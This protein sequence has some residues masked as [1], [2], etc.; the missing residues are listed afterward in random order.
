MQRKD[1]DILKKDN[2]INEYKMKVKMMNEE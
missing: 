2:N 1:E